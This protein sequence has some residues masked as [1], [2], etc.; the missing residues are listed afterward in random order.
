MSALI[1]HLTTLLKVIAIIAALI[2]AEMYR[3]GFV[4]GMCA[5][6]FL[7]AM[8]YLAHAKQK[9]RKNSSSEDPT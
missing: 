3:P 2:L 1:H 9:K 7:V 4:P 5:A 6:F 8:A